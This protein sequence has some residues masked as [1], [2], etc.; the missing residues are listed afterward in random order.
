MV[1]CIFLCDYNKEFKVTVYN[2]PPFLN[3]PCLLHQE[4]QASSK[5][6]RKK[7]FI[8]V[9]EKNIFLTIY[10]KLLEVFSKIVY[11]SVTA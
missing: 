8:N 1:G 7:K 5:Y 10:K 9:F 11:T 2:L 6:C 4:K 3:F